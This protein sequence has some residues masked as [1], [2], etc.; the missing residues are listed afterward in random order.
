LLVVIFLSFQFFFIN[1]SPV[2][3]SYNVEPTFDF[4]DKNGNFVLLTK[5]KQIEPVQFV[6][7]LS[8]GLNFVRHCCQKRQQCRL[9]AFDSVASTLLLVWTCFYCSVNLLATGQTFF[10]SECA[11]RACLFRSATLVCLSGRS[12]RQ[13]IR[14]AELSAG[15]L[16]TFRRKAGK[17][18]TRSV[19]RSSMCIAS[20]SSSGSC[21]PTRNRSKTVPY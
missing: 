3:T 8:K 2:H 15:P 6:S 17:T 19:R 7:T 11:I 9:V 18:S 20:V 5:S 14:A 13:R 10:A 12:I 21:W 1:L 4:V 16:V